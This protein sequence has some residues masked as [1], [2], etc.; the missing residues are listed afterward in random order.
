MVANKQSDSTAR[1]A[2]VLFLT[3]Q[4]ATRFLLDET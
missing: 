3:R 1:E 2:A 4:V